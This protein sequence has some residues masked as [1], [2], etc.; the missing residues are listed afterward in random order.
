MRYLLETLKELLSFARS[1]PFLQSSTGLLRAAGHFET[2]KSRRQ[3]TIKP[4][5]RTNPPGCFPATHHLRLNCR[6]RTAA[7]PSCPASAFG[8]HLVAK[9]LYFL[10]PLGT[11]SLDCAAAC[12][13]LQA[14]GFQN[15]RNYTSTG[16]CPQPRHDAKSLASGL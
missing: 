10:L 1:A 5:Q 16:T 4:L 13:F 8:F 14:Q 6:Q 7:R 9:E 11:A 12:C 2:H 3:L 15:A